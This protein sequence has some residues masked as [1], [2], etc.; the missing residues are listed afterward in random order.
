MLIVDAR[1]RLGGLDRMIVVSP[2]PLVDDPASL[3]APSPI[4]P[5]LPV[6]LALPSDERATDFGED[7]FGLDDR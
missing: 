4:L 7:V 6:V 3:S 1:S 5:L 2:S